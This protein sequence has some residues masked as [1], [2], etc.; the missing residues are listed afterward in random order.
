MQYVVRSTDVDRTLMSAESQMSALFYPTPEQQF[1]QTI[2]WQPIPVH[3]VPT[4]DDFVSTCTQSKYNRCEL[5]PRSDFANFGTLLVGKSLQKAN[6]N[7]CLDGQ[8]YDGSSQ[9]SCLLALANK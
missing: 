5:A 3:T 6:S 1:N 4:T 9:I 2:T 8:T 7:S